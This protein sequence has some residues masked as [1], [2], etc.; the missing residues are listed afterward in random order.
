[1]ERTQ[2]NIEF[3][4]EIPSLGEDIRQEVRD[5][6]GALKED[7]K[8]MIEASIAI[9]D[10][11]GEE[12]PYLYKVRIV[13]YMRPENIAVVEKGETIR[14][15]VKDALSTMERRVRK[16]RSRLKELQQEPTQKE[17]DD[18]YTLS[19]EE[20]YETYTPSR[21][22][23]VLLEEGRSELASFLMME[24]EIGQKTAYYIADQILEYAAQAQVG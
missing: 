1:M 10:I 13:V 24:K 5:R 6:L 19:P 9:E 3:Y 20:L 18:L 23:K 2:L 17:P 11:A 15:T 8:D 22:V 16:E 4:S 14:K 7:R 12:T 21:D